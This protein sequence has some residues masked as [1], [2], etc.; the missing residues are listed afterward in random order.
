MANRITR[1]VALLSSFR[2]GG[3]SLVKKISKGTIAIDPGNIA[4]V[5]RGAITWTLTGARAG[6]IVH[7]DPPATLNDDLIFCGTRV[8]ADDTVTVY[9]YNP[10][11]G[12]IDDTSK[13]WD[14]L[15]ID[16]T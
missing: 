2:V 15:W 9:L 7:M 13:T 4:T 12:G 16:L 14:Y 11:G 10:T 6:D 8:T 1:G 3:G 5:S